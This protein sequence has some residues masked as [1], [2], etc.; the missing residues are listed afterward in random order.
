ML[1]DGVEKFKMRPAR[2]EPWTLNFTV[3]KDD[4][5][6]LHK[7]HVQRV[8]CQVSVFASQVIFADFFYLS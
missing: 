8:I 5:L 6:M 4:A 7:L 1:L 3:N 2:F